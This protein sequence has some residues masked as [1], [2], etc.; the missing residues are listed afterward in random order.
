[1]QPTDSSGVAAFDTIFVGHYSGRASHIHL[2]AHHGG[3]VLSNGTY[4]GGNISHVGQLFFPEDLKT[5]VEAT[6]PYDT[7]TQAVTTNDEDMWTPDQADNSYDP[8]PEYAYLGEEIE[9]GLLMWISV[10][11]DLSAD[12]TVEIAAAYGADGGVAPTSDSLGSGAGAGGN[13]NGTASGNM[14]MPSGG[15]GTAPTGTVNGTALTGV[16]G[17]TA[18][19]SSASTSLAVGGTGVSPSLSVTVA[20]SST[21]SLVSASS[22]SS[23]SSS[24][25]LIHI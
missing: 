23:S 5:A 17:G 2:I 12:Y 10:G 22:S 13:G 14:T 9:D 18:S 24:L 8:F 16:M 25:S 15:N 21:T 11:V 7:N 1:M 20:T 19:M 6:F 3:T 4:Q